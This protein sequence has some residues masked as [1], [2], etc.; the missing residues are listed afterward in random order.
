MALAHHSGCSRA[1]VPMLTRRQ[2]VAIAA[3]SDSSSRMPPLISTLMSRL[4]TIRACSSRLWPRPNAASRS[5]R[6]I[7]SAPASCQRSAASTGSPNRFSEPATPWTSWTAWPSAMST[8]GNSSRYCF[9]DGVTTG[10]T[11]ALPEQHHVHDRRAQQ[12]GD[13]GQAGE[14]PVLAE[15]EDQQVDGD[16]D[17]ERR[18]GLAPLLL[19]QQAG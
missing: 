6:W 14:V 7:H 17:G 13:Q 4:P 10:I 3:S 5:T 18:P 2:P 9:A 11:S 12:A 19:G 15:R 16:Q 8:A 1:A